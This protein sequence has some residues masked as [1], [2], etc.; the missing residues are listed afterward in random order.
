M[1]IPSIRRLAV[2]IS[3]IVNCVSASRKVRRPQHAAREF[4]FKAR[5]ATPTDVLLIKGAELPL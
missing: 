2:M 3:L 4:L 5:V 1:T